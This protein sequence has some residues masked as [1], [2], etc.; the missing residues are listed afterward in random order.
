MNIV[1]STPLRE[2][3]VLTQEVSVALLIGVWGGMEV[4]QRLLP[5]PSLLVNSWSKRLRPR[6]VL[7]KVMLHA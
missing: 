4:T 7:D 5:P 1:V 6:Y 3:P 2:S